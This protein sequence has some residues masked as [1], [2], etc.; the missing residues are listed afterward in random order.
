MLQPGLLSDSA[1][2]DRLPTVFLQSMALP[3]LLKQGLTLRCKCSQGINPYRCGKKALTF[4]STF[5]GILR[6]SRDHKPH[7]EVYTELKSGASGA[8]GDG[9]QPQ[10]WCMA[11]AWVKSTGCSR[12]LD[13]QSE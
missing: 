4:Y 11:C 1:S 10:R 8:P 9:K 13:L 6:Y 7:P 5:H 12:L 3:V 2:E